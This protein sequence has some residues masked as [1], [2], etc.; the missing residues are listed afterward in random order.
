MKQKGYSLTELMVVVCIIG[1][2]SAL[3]VEGYK[4]IFKMIFG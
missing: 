3:A 2:L 4:T 1:I